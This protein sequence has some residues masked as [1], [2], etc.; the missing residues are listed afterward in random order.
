M[1]FL[2]AD[3]MTLLAALASGLLWINKKL[4]AIQNKLDKDDE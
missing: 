1:S 4:E 2:T 3:T